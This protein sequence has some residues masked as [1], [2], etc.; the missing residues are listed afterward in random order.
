MRQ[1]LAFIE[2]EFY[3]ISRDRWTVIILLLM[4]IVMLV[5]FGYA[6]TTEVRNTVVGVYDPSRDIVTRGLVDKLMASPYFKEARYLAS[7]DEI[8]GAFKGG[9]FGLVVV[10]SERFAESMARTGEAEVLLVADGSDPNTARTLVSY[11]TN[12]MASYSSDDPAASPPPYRIVSQVKLLY[13]PQMRGAYNFVP[14]VMGMILILICAMM[15]SISIAREKE[16]GTM[17]IL[18]VSPMKPILILL[19]KVV[20]FFA[21]SIVNLTTILLLSVFVLKV[22]V[23]G[24]LF[25][26]LAVSLEY[27]FLALSLGLLIS[28]VANTQATALLISGMALM[29]PIVLLSGM[30][31]PVENMPLFLRIISGA[32]PARWY[33]LAVRK[34]MI[35]G[36]G[37]SAIAWEMAI[38]GGMTLLILAAG[39]KK[40]KIRLE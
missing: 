5:L 20:P 16:K 36:L 30:M 23:A 27:I 29:M 19:A 34:I 14:G 3:H 6:I 35:K 7:P 15:T 21:L 39:L 37:F 38:L 12:I 18:L 11:A 26:L 17:E 1:F 13:N 31:F 24:S 8:E 2:K 33:I 25:W 28:S 22:P 9:D 32:I 10:F 40:F 4:P